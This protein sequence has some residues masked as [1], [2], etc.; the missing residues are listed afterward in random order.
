M[1]RR[2]STQ[3]PE[4][5]DNGSLA[6]TAVDPEVQQRRQRISNVNGD[7]CRH[8]C[9]ARRLIYDRLPPEY[10]AAAAHD[11]LWPILPAALEA[12]RQSSTAVGLLV[13][14]ALAA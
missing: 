10:L 4:Y 1:V 2:Q 5:D 3:A 14:L 13:L 11:F 6:A 12:R 7:R 8:D 9:T